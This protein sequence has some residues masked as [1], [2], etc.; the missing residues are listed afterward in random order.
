MLGQLTQIALKTYVMAQSFSL[1]NMVPQAPENNRG[2]WAKSVEKPQQP[3]CRM[4]R[5]WRRGF[6]LANMV[7][8]APVNNQKSWAGIE[9]ATHKHA[10]RAAGDVYV[11]SGLVFEGNSQTIGPG[12]IRV[13]KYLYKLVYDSTSG[14]AWAHWIENTD[15]ARAGQPISY[16]ELVR[17]T[18]IEFLP[19]VRPKG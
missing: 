19:G 5:Q 7:P 1:A 11:I 16:E 14:R 9:K 12:R 10:M 17:R 2:P 4:R 13:P 18:G 8:Q 6:S 15:E 3:T